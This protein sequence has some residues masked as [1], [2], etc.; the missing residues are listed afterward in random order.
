MA[1]KFIFICNLVNSAFTGPPVSGDI[2]K[3]FDNDTQLVFTKG[4]CEPLKI[5]RGKNSYGSFN[6]YYL[7]DINSIIKD[8]KW[9]EIDCTTIYQ[10]YHIIT[11]K[12]TCTF[13][14]N[15]RDVFE[16][17]FQIPSVINSGVIPD[18]N[19]KFVISYIE[20]ISYNES[21]FFEV[22]MIALLLLLGLFY[23]FCLQ[24]N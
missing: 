10:I 22:Y 21:D 20:N 13:S 11:V 16:D 7:S 6:F 17:I 3:C 4:P 5:G 12:G 1:F 14:T 24:S 18:E 8:L 19:K 2:I 23:L 15:N 9:K